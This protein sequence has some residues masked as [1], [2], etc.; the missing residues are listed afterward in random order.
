M[1]LCLCLVST[2]LMAAGIKFPKPTYI[3]GGAIRFP[4]SLQPGDKGNVYFESFLHIE[5]P[6][7]KAEKSEITFFTRIF[8]SKDSQALTFNNRSKVSVGLAYTR[9]LHKTFS[10]KVSVKYDHDYG[11]LS[12][13]TAT[14]LRANLSY[15]YYKSRWRNMPRDQKG[16]FRQK[17]WTRAWGVLTFPENLDP[18]D[19][20]LAFITGLEAATAFV[21]PTGK[22]QYVPF[23]ELIFA[24][25][26]DKLS[27]NNKIIPAA[28]FKFRLPIKGGEI[29]LGVKYAIDRRWISGTTEY[30]P[31][32]FGGWY[33]S[34]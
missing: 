31:V 9:K 18:G 4:Y 8:Y 27:F 25:D 32:I 15:S 21:R 1:Y 33:R 2:P 24:K 10:V 16:W 30:G 7:W 29:N 26:S 14:G 19:R 34:F 23:V 22:L 6:V 17:S 20:N 12:G 28:G 13:K 3:T 11:M 5:L